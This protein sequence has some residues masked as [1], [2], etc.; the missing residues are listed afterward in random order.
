MKKFVPEILA[1]LLLGAAVAVLVRQQV[2][3][4]CPT[5]FHLEEIHSYEALASFLV[6]GGVAL[7]IGKYLGRLLR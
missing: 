5:F 7:V 2:V 3:T 4:H 1:L 6:V